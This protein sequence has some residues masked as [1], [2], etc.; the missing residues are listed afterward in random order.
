MTDRALT[1]AEIAKIAETWGDVVNELY[2]V[3]REGTQGP[4]SGLV[5]L[6]LLMSQV[7][8]DLPH[9]DSEIP[10]EKDVEFL[11]AWLRTVAPAAIRKGR[12]ERAEASA[13][14]N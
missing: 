9:C 10:P 1:D 11:M 5:V 14:V 6:G 2:G 8:A 13:S 7:I 12:R 3:L 4:R